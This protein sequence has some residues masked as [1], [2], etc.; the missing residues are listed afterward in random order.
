[1]KAIFAALAG[2][3]MA[4]SAMAQNDLDGITCPVPAGA[5]AVKIPDGMPPILR[6]TLVSSFG[7]FALP[8][9]PFDGTDTG[10]PGHDRRFIFVW[11][12]GATWVVATE[13]GGIAYN[14]PILVYEVRDGGQSIVLVKTRIAFPTTL[15]AL[16]T[17]FVEE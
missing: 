17:T 4:T 15:C 11:N 5:T 12:R 10:S 14:D 1:M 13:H 2:V 16:A 3:L 7:D 9:Q 6:E 8:G